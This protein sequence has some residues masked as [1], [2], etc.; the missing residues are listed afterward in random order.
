MELII[1]TGMSGAGK[2]KVIE[3]MEDIGY[4]CVDNMPTKLISKFTNLAEQSNGTINK[5]AIVVD[6][7]AGDMFNEFTTE[8]DL[9]L[10]NEINFKVLFLDANENTLLKRYKETRRKHPL[11]ND[12]N[13]SL[14]NAIKKEKELLKKAKDRANY[15]IDTTYLTPSQLKEKINSIFLD[16]IS[17]S[18]L[19]NTMSFGFKFGYPSE[20]D[21]VFDVRCLPN[22]FYIDDL[23][24]KTGLNKEVCDYVMQFEQAQ[25]LFEKLVDL[26]D[27]LIPLYINE[28][29][30]QLVIAF[31]CTGGKHR[32]VTFAEYMY[33]HLK[34][35]NKRVIVNH[36]DIT[37]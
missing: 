10:E 8:L 17:S 33:K 22:P 12:E 15:I 16:N 18:I 30:T 25:K 21:L 2:S 24:E 29:K 4:Y 6:A 14:S 34:E 31:G 20:A 1:I 19:I 26:I 7:R 5:M 27:F 37:K 11:L 9:L 36:R 32:S 28:G 23:K 13:S 35:K 3:N